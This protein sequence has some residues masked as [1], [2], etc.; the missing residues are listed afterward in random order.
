MLIYDL[1]GHLHGELHY[2]HESWSG[3]AASKVWN[4]AKEISRV[5]QKNAEAFIE[6]MQC[7]GTHSGFVSVPY[8][9]PFRE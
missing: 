6:T 7:G 1:K 9:K 4:K 8:E 2:S 5:N 3:S